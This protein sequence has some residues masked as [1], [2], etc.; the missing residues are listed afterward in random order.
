MPSSVG[1]NTFGEENLV[2]GYD[3]GDVANSYK[4]EPT[5]NLT[6]D[7]PLMSGWQGT[8]TLVNTT[9]KTF[10]IETKQDNAATTSAW[11]TYYWNVSSY[12]G[13]YITISA[14]IKFISETNCNFRD[15]HIG[16]G[17]TGSFPLHIAGSS[18]Q[19]KVSTSIRPITKIFMTWSGIVN[20]TGI[21]G[22]TQWIH[23]VTANGANSIL[24]VSNIQIES[25]SHATPYVNGTRS[26]TQALID[27]KS[28]STIDLTNV[29]FDSNAQMTF[30]GSNDYATLSSASHPTGSCSMEI[31]FNHT[32]NFV[33]SRYLLYG[34]NGTAFWVFFRGD[35]AGN[36]LYFTR[37]VTNSGNYG[38]SAWGYTTGIYQPV[39]ANETMHLIF[40]HD[41][42]SGEFKCYKNGILTRTVNGNLAAYGALNTTQQS[43]YI[44]GSPSDNL[45]MTLPLFKFYNRV[46]TA[47]E[48]QS[49]YN[50]I[51]GRFNI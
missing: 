6:T 49:N 29:S 14:N 50:A 45:P 24:E 19:D 44:G 28:T 13:L 34:A 12:V 3:L 39:P 21:V 48:I 27:L 46:L 35:W 4:G 32:H 17:N 43:H 11:R 8:F 2:F 9:S 10:I 26:A 25:K 15:F 41:A 38:D 42:S 33:G 1:P 20:A 30:D 36:L 47:S 23:N 22:F 18:A 37:R 51:K 5:V 16:Q 40:T 31:V 7:T